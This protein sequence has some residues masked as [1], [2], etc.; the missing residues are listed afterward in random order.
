MQIRIQ[1]RERKTFKL[2]MC[3]RL[4]NDDRFGELVAE[5]TD[6]QWDI[7]MFGETRSSHG[8]IELHECNFRRKCFG[9]GTETC[10]AGVAVLLHERHAKNVANA[11]VISD[12]VMYMDFTNGG[13]KLRA[14]AVSAPHEVYNDDD[15]NAFF[16]QLHVVI[17]GACKEGRQTILGGDFNL[18]LQV[19]NRGDQID[20][21]ANAFWF[22]IANSGEHH[23]PLAET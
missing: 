3:T 2:Y 15:F 4:H 11:K 19:G 1:K 10:S 7:V 20:A 13:R 12:R 8:I 17:L 22:T 6:V 9:S 23:S 21:L 14:I 16:E 18:Q 5:I